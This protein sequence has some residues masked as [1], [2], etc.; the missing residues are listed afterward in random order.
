MVDDVFDEE[1]CDEK[2]ARD[3]KAKAE[4]SSVGSTFDVL[5]SVALVVL[6][7]TSAEITFRRLFLS[8]DIIGSSA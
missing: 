5:L 4:A 1:E 6:V 3:A 8:V 2:V 7:L